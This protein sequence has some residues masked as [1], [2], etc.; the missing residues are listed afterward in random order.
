[1]SDRNIPEVEEDKVTLVA[2]YPYLDEDGHILY[3]VD[4]FS[5]KQFKPRTQVQSTGK[6]VRKRLC[7][8]VLY[9]LPYLIGA[10]RNKKTIL[11][12][13][14]EKDANTCNSKLMSENYYATTNCA[15]ALNWRELEHSAVLKD[16]DCIILEDNDEAGRK[17]TIKIAET[18]YRYAKS[19][20]YVSF[21][22][23]LPEHG[24]ITD[25]V[26]T[27]GI[28]T[29]LAK[30]AEAK[31]VPKSADENPVFY[32]TPQP[33]E[34]TGLV[35]S[36][37]SKKA[38]YQDYIDFLRTIP[39]ISEIKRDILSGRLM[40][41]D[42]GTW[43]PLS[44]YLSYIKSRARDFGTFFDLPAWED[45]LERYKLE[46]CQPELL[47]TLPKWDGRDRILEQ[48][49]VFKFKNLS[50]QDFYELALS[51]GSN[52]FRRLED[53]FVQ[54]TTIILKGGQGLGKDSL[55]QAWTGG[56]GMYVKNLTLLPG[57]PQETYRQLHK[58][59][60]FVI[61]EMD[62]AAKMDIAML[63]QVL[64]T[65]TTDIRLPFA[66]DDET[67]FIRASFIASCNIEDIFVDSTGNRRFWVFDCEFLGLKKPDGV[68]L[69]DL[70]AGEV[71]MCNYP[72]LWS[73]PDRDNNRAQIL[74]QFRHWA[75]LGKAPNVDIL[76]RMQRYVMEQT[77][78]DAVKLLIEDYRLALTNS[79]SYI[80]TRKSPRDG[81]DLYPAACVNPLIKILA[82]DYGKSIAK[83]T[84]LLKIQG[85]RERLS[86]G[87]FYR[88]AAFSG[89]LV[90]DSSISVAENTNEPK[91]LDADEEIW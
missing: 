12:C 52:I 79:V 53:P 44:N 54:P 34:A 36:K 85:L 86:G 37:K 72:G 13:E 19:V 73:D 84:S 58:A 70:G 41:Q 63:K 62:R 22:E 69:D 50:Q 4:R 91:I 45:H 26:E 65:P 10:I 9:N 89:S 75:S 46:N 31:E 87:M 11:I 30:L 7:E 18:L 71:T 23:E 6:W 82:K 80:A 78:E 83:V 5:N 28:N 1:M 76:A 74:A 77:P 47:I 3:Y 49:K 56:L 40:T 66:R 81:A 90:Q 16:A 55:I 64:T 2:S 15:G 27:F 43:Q 29:T 67:R 20:K 32:F 42:K 38:T 35:R 25:F 39:G 21:E 8:P 57:Q 51:W 48:S 88:A 14:G 24:D 17:R 59:L 68:V 61:S 60:V 33:S